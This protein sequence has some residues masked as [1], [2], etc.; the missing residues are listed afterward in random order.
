MIIWLAS[1]PKSGNTWL[2]FFIISLLAGDKDNIN[3]S[4]LKA[5]TSFPTKSQFEGLVKDFKSLVE[6]AK[7][8]QIAQKKINFDKKIRFLKTHNMLNRYKNSFFTDNE[9]TLGTIYIARDPRN[10]ITSLKNHFSYTEYDE[11]KKFLFNENQAIVLSN[12]QE[13]KI[14]NQDNFQLPQFVGSWQTH[15][16]SWKNMK[17]NLLLIKY[18]NLIKTP[19][20]E[21]VK[22]AKF[23]EKMLKIR[24]TKEQI[25]KSI[26]L[27]S[28][29]K[30]QKMEEKKGFIEST[31]NKLTGQKNK[32]FYLGPKN[33]WRKILDKEIADEISSR[34]EPEMKELGYL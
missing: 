12:S 1:Y 17:K 3:L 23:L 31:E 15:Y 7:N 9:N 6:V 18:E 32:F 26:Y 34:F 19:D 13:K 22:I 14:K 30:L 5:I 20:L 8:W 16:K 4:H 33:D 10:I 24:F 2:R 25:E 21:F 27:S 11:A 29:D 28:F